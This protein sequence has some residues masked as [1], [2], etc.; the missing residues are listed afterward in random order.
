MK[1]KCF[2]MLLIL[3]FMLCFNVDIIAQNDFKEIETSPIQLLSYKEGTGEIRGFGQASS[4]NEQLALNVAKAQATADL[5]TKIEQYV[6]YGLNHYLDETSAENSSFLDEKQQNDVIIAAKSVIKDAK[7]LKTRK[8]YSESLRKYKYEV[9]V[10]YDRAGI[11]NVIEA[12]NERILKNRERFEKDMQMAWDELDKHNGRL[13]S[14]EKLAEREARLNEM[15]QGNLDRDNQ[16]LID[17][18][19]AKGKNLVELEKAR[20]KNAM[21]NEAK[22]EAQKDRNALRKI[23]TQKNAPRNRVIIEGD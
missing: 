7:I 1:I 8:L 14:E 3:A 21:D 5:Q 15:E 22:R 20:S 18:E 4:S 23:A 13:T 6:Q 10:K 19:N 12:Q 2:G 9:C 17:L 16:R 11:L